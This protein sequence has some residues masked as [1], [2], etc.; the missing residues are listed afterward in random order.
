MGEVKIKKLITDTAHFQQRREKV[1]KEFPH[2]ARERERKME[3]TNGYVRIV[4]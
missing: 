3:D 1:V 4:K 2:P